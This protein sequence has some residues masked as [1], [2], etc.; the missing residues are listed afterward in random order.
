MYLVE[1]TAAEVSDLELVRECVRGVVLGGGGDPIPATTDG[2]AGKASAGG[3]HAVGGQQQGLYHP[4]QRRDL[5]RWQEQA[6]RCEVLI[7]IRE[8]EELRGVC[9][10]YP[11]VVALCG[12]DDKAS[13]EDSVQTRP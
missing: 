10:V 2:R 6:H 1:E 12:H 7:H 4:G 3:K 9:Q 8:R 5:Q 11:N 13:W